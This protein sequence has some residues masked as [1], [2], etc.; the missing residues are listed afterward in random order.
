[1]LQ[2]GENVATTEVPTK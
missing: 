1:M 2:Q